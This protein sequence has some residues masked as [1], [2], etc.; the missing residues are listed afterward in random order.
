MGYI[1]I[2]LDCMHTV[3]VKTWF[4]WLK[5]AFSG[6]SV[7]SIVPFFPFLFGSHISFLLRI[8]LLL[9]VVLL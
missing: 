8:S 6:I 4:Q 5:R 2:N 1:Y 3:N 7:C 9:A